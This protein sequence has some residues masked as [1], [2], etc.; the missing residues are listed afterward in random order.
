[1][2][3]SSVAHGHYA[4]MLTNLLQKGWYFTLLK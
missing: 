3:D 4:A 2:F 1:M